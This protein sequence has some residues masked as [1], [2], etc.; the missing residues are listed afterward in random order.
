[1]DFSLV[2]F[3]QSPVGFAFLGFF[4]GAWHRLSALAFRKTEQTVNEQTGTTYTLQ[5]S[6]LDGIVRLTNAAAITLTVGPLDLADWPIGGEVQLIR[7]GAGAVTCAAGSLQT[8][9]VGANNRTKINGQYAV[10][11]VRRLAEAEWIF[12]GDTST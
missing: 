4:S 12:Y 8:L 1:M 5:A 3:R 6:D 2:P 10:A 9:R 11:Y 7:G